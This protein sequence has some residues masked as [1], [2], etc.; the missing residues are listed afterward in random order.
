MIKNK[1]LLCTDMDKTVIPSGPQLE[2][3]D[4]RDRFRAFCSQPNVSLVYVSGWPL[5]LVMRAIVEYNLPRPHYAITDM[6]TKIYHHH[7]GVWSD[8]ESWQQ[9]IA[10]A[11]GGKSHADL[12]Q[13]LCS[14]QDLQLQESSKQNDYK[15]CYSLPL[16]V[17]P[18][19]ILSW[20]EQQLAKQK[21][22]FEL[23]WSVDDIKRVGLLDILPRNGGKKDAIEFLR[24]QLNIELDQVLFAGDSGNDLPVLS[25][26]IKSVLVA[27]AEPEIRKQAIE[28]AAVYDCSDSLYIAKSEKNP[29]DGNYS[30]GVMQG[31]SFF[32]PDFKVNRP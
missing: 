9:S 25:S 2:H 13:A 16:S 12:Q 30:A 14:C 32:Y 29:F 27:N 8:V 4:A 28:L 24:R 26:P 19:Q 6:G 15:L 3:P 17:P 10:S 7:E 22:E 18:K 31:I 1:L 23:I 20:V 21:I 11:W 5:N